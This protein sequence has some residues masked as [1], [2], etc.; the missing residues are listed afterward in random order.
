MIC[1][2]SECET[3]LIMPDTREEQES[4]R[5]INQSKISISHSP[6]S[7]EPVKISQIILDMNP[8]ANVPYRE[9]NFNINY[10]D[11]KN[12]S[13]CK[14]WIH[15]MLIVYTCQCTHLIYSFMGLHF[16]FAMPIWK[17]LKL[18]I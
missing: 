2:V 3:P 8:R 15:P 13:Q 17:L 5:A 14:Y 6:R 10:Q 11:N 16:Y 4:Y 9:N 18:H 12:T 1:L 7:S